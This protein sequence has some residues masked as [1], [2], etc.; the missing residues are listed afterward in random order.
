M[1]N[2]NNQEDVLF[3]GENNQNNKPKSENLPPLASNGDINLWISQETDKNGNY[4]LKID[5]PFL[6]TETVFPHDD[7][8]PSLNE[9][10][11]NWKQQRN[12][13]EEEKQ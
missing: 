6:D 2:D 5:A 11:Q 9:I 7:V 12:G 4:Y 13:H 3:N 8:K 1:N 10:V